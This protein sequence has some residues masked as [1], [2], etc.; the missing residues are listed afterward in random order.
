MLFKF[1]VGVFAFCL[2]I[3]S[4]YALLDSLRSDES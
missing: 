3:F 4:I 1:I 2:L